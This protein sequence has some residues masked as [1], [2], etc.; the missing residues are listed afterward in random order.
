MLASPAVPR[1]LRTG[2]PVPT[3]RQSQPPP[4][5]REPARLSC[6]L[7]FLSGQRIVR[8]GFGH[9]REVVMT[10]LAGVLFGA[11]RVLGSG[12]QASAD[13]P[14]LAPPQPGVPRRFTASE[15]LARTDCA[16]V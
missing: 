16:E 5:R 11:L 7:K 13:E 1:Q 9:F 3:A 10:R 6:R 2:S 4:L 15:L 8:L 12:G 14:S